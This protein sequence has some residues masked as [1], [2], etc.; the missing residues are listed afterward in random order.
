MFLYSKMTL[1]ECFFYSLGFVEKY[2]IHV[3]FDTIKKIKDKN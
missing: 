3:T 1:R 2:L